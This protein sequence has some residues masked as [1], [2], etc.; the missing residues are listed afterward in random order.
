MNTLRSIDRRSLVVGILSLLVI[1][2]SAAGAWRTLSRRTPPDTDLHRGV[3]AALAERTRAVVGPKGRI[4]VVLLESGDSS[5]IDV[6]WKAFRSTIEGTPGI[7]IVDRERISAEGKSKYGPGTGLSASRLA[8]LVA[9]HRDLDA[10][11]SFVGLPDLDSK[12]L[13]E[14]GDGGP[15]LIAY[16]RSAKRVGPW[17]AAKR[18]EAAAVPRFQFPA[19]VSDTPRSPS[20]W[21]DLRCQ[22][23]TPGDLVPEAR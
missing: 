19:P 2:I 10:I 13:A 20:E 22:W 23:I 8:R 3:G 4:L 7:A 14:L 18:V 6:Q 5:A 1:G 12:E 16:A 21:F 15:K 11:V 9:K 17:L